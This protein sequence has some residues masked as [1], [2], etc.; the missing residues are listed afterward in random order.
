[1]PG[2]TVTGARRHAAS[3]YRAVVLC[4]CEA[5]RV[6]TWPRRMRGAFE[7]K[8]LTDVSVWLS[9]CRLG[10]CEEKG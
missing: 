2:K 1:M 3:G 7:R 9:R 6:R 10:R 4:V 8:F 5:E